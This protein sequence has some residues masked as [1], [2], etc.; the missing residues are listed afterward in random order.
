MKDNQIII[1]FSNVL[2][3]FLGTTVYP[4]DI[5][6]TRSAGWYYYFPKGFAK[7]PTLLSHYR[8]RFFVVLPGD[9]VDKLLS[10]AVTPDSYILSSEWAIGYYQGGYSPIDGAWLTPVGHIDTYFSRNYAHI[11]RCMTVARACGY[12]ADAETCKV[13]PVYD[14]PFS[15]HKQGDLEKYK[16]HDFRDDLIIALADRIS[17]ELGF[18]VKGVMAHHHRPGLENVVT[19]EAAYSPNSVTISIPSE[20]LMDLLYYPM[21]E[22]DFANMAQHFEF[23]IDHM[24]IS[25]KENPHWETI[26]I[27]SGKNARDFMLRFWAKHAAQKWVKDA[28]N[29][30]QEVPES[31]ETLGIVKAQPNFIVRFFRNLFKK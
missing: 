2:S 22:R 23:K 26:D 30:S 7:M 27:P 3:A 29:E 9:D 4:E 5:Y 10:G 14:C 16:K 28:L 18:E 1:H 24:D 31:E 8:G 12:R 11:M 13:C 19:I 15:Q 20:I 21:V 6:D 25:D 17:E